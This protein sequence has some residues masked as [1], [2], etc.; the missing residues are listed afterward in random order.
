MSTTPVLPVSN[1][2]SISISSPPLGLANFNVNNLAIISKEIPINAVPASGYFTYLTA[3]QVAS[4]W[5]STSETAQQA[6]MIF[7][8]PLNILAGGGA[9]IVY[10]IAGG[11]LLA[12]AMQTLDG[13]V[14]FGGALVA[15]W[16]PSTAEYLAAAI[17][18][19][20]S[21]TLLGV[22]SPLLSDLVT[23][24][25]F[26]TLLAT[27]NPWARYFFYST[28]ALQARLNLAGYFSLG[29]STNFTGF[30]TTQTLHLKQIV[31]ASPDPAITQSVLAEA[32][33]CGADVYCNIGGLP[34]I[35]T[36][37][38]NQFWDQ[39]YNQSWFAFALE[40]AIF[41]AIAQ[42]NTKVPQ[43]EPGIATLRNAALQVCA[44]AVTN[45]YL[46]PGTWNGSVTFG[47]ANQLVNNITENGYYIYTQPVSQQSQTARAA[48]SAPLMQIAGKQAGAVQ[49][50]SV[51]VFV[52]P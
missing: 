46:A 2:V 49:N 4:D 18:A 12:A 39:I 9:L 17:Y 28:S 44:Q 32:Q 19:A 41:N 50:S 25:L 26:P 40:V 3:S 21:E 51:V 31:G 7:G 10:P 13:L 27:T 45:G 34:E 43:T 37:G 33:A 8:Q 52:Q 22:T 14:F 20:A 38:A 24:G 23:T 6:S 30:N 47:P 36:S 29:M 16:Q 1:V 5:G 48:R 42:T 11:T 35:F 15:G